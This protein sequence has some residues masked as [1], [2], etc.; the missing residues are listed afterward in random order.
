MNKETTVIYSSEIEDYDL[1]R[2]E[3]END[4]LENDIE[5]EESGEYQFWADQLEFDWDD[6]KTDIIP[7]IE[8]Q[9]GNCLYLCVGSSGLWTGRHSGGKL[10]REL[11]P[12]IREPANNLDDFSVTLVDGH[13]ETAGHHHDGSNYYSIYRLNGRAEKK[14]EKWED[15]LDDRELH[16]KL[17][18]HYYLG[19][20]SNPFG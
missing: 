20:I 2:S 5:P 6:M 7:T 1:L 15:L 4:C 12:L 11:Y 16:E 18:R 9:C 3:Y 17:F 13:L 10:G 14:V 8:K 19:K